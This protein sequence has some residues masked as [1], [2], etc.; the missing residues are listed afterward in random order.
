MAEDT[1]KPVEYKNISAAGM[2]FLKPGI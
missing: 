2:Y 1:L